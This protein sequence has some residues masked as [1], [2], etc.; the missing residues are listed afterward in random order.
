[1]AIDISGIDPTKALHH[2]YLVVGDGT[3][4]YYQTN[5]ANSGTVNASVL[6]S[7]KINQISG[8]YDN[9]FDDTSYYVT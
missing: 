1:M 3:I 5:F 7:P 9:R 4:N 2:G 6:T 8:L